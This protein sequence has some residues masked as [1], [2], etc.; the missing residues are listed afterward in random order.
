[1][2]LNK[3]TGDFAVLTNYRTVN[4]RLPGDYKSRGNLIME[5]VKIRDETIKDESKMFQSIEDYENNVF[6]HMYKGFNL[7]YGNTI[8]SSFKYYSHT[9]D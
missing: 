9:N 2:A 3:L 8:T 1:M 7:I 4:N 6:K 5:Y